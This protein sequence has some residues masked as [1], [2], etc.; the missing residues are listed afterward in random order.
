MEALVSYARSIW[1][2][3]DAKTLAATGAVIGVSSHLLYWMHGLRAPQSAQIFWFHVTAFALTTALSIY[4]HGV[5]DGITVAGVL[6]GSYLAGVFTSISIYRVFFHRLSRFPGPFPA[7]VSKLYSTWKARHLNAHNDVM[8]MHEKYGDI[9]RSGPMDLMIR[10]GEAVQ[11]VM[12]ANSSCTKRGMGVFEIFDLH[13]GFSLEA[14]L[15]SDVHRARRQIWDRAQNSQAMAKYETKT[16]TVM[17]TWLD[18]LHNLDGAPIEITEAVLLVAFDNMGKVGFTKEFGTTSTG[19]GVRWLNLLNAAFGRIARLG[20]VPWPILIVKSVGLLGDIQEFNDIS[21]ATAEDRM[22]RDDPEM[23]DILKYFIQDFKS[24]KPKSFRSIYDLYTDAETVLVAA[25]DTGAASIAWIFYYLTK[26]P[27]IKRRLLD[28]IRPAFGKTVPGEYTDSDLAQVDYLNAVINETLRIQ[29]VAGISSPRLTPPQGIVVD[30][31]WI[32]G[33]VQVFC[34]PW[35][36]CRSEKFF[37][38]ADEFIPERWTT[39]PELVLDKRAFIPFNTGRWSCAGKKIA[40][41]LMRFIVAY[42]L[43]EYDFDFAPGE[44]GTA[45]IRDTVNVTMVKPG[46]LNLSFK[47]RL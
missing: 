37:V 21:A 44:D 28:E 38:H 10:S 36:F 27:E 14:I 3:H 17:R 16:R 39:R 4:S 32:P 34:P 40:M 20:G 18:R 43:T 33:H 29:P 13:G 45:I 26:N 46:K 23:E 15:D 42:T 7:K 5:V 9:V 47:K 19:Q 31:V 25:T 41:L 30:G 12:G 35:I 8:A 2:E 11:K 1:L 6:N 22:K 24:E